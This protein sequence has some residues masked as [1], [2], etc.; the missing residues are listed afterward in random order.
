MGELGKEKHFG[1]NFYKWHDKNYKKLLI[2]PLILVLF[3]IIYMISFYSSTGDFIHKDISLTGGTSA[4]IYDELISIEQIEQDLSLELKDLDIRQISDVATGKQKAIIIQTISPGEETKTILENYF[5]YELIEGENF[6]FEFTGASLSDSFY[7]QLIFALIIAFILI[8]LVIFI[9]FKKPVPSLTV[10]FSTF[11]NILMTLT[12]AN[13]L[14]IKMS[15]AGIMSL[16]MILGYSIDTDILL[17]NKMLKRKE[18]SINER[19]SGAAKT[20]LRMTL[21]SLISF[22]II[23][24]IVQSFS[25]VLS[26]IFT[27]LSIGL[28]FD[29]INTWVTNVSVI[30][31]NLLKKE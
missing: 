27:I 7:K 24:L 19:I 18:V 25:N 3:S 14:E 11:A 2:V 17:T 15:T 1:S 9:M 12:L 10:I 26:Q 22:I 5:D 16:L 4:T 8:G 23:L 31:W 30:K 21:T 20:G 13:I 6:D 28:F 29:L